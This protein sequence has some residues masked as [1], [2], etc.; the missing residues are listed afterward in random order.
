MRISGGG[1]RVAAVS[2]LALLFAFAALFPLGAEA[3]YLVVSE[4]ARTT[5]SKGALERARQ[6]GKYLAPQPYYAANLAR[7]YLLFAAEFDD[8]YYAR[9]SAKIVEHALGYAPVGAELRLVRGTTYLTVAE[10]TRDEADIEKAHQSL[11]E[12]HERTPTMLSTNMDL[13]ELYL[14]EGDYRAVIEI[15]DLVDSFKANSV[16]SMLARVVALEALGRE[17]EARR[18]YKEARKLDPEAS[19]IKEWLAELKPDSAASAKKAVSD[20]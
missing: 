4:E 1:L 18:L 2:V 3:R 5:L 14:L 15:A 19:G 9:E 7:V 6:A 16:R 12:A 10:L 13:L 11:E 8:P 20:E 17:D